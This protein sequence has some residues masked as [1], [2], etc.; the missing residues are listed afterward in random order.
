MNT[1]HA[2][3]F[4]SLLLSPIFLSQL[5][6]SKYEKILMT[7]IRDKNTSREKYRACV[8]KLANIL[9][10]KVYECLPTA[11]TVIDTPVDRYRGEKLSSDI[12]L[13]SVLRSGDALLTTFM[14]HFPE[15]RVSKILIQRNEKSLEPE[16]HYMKL[17]PTIASGNKVVITE[18][19]IGTGGTLNHVITKLKSRGVREENILI[20]SVCASQEGINRIKSKFPLIQVIVTE[21]DTELTDSGW[22]SPGLGDFGDR[23]FGTE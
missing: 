6:A 12:E 5:P 4:L 15:A 10:E 14:Q 3:V 22:I 8:D 13:L 23:F 16:F 2:F 19:M 21:V 11:E 20:A 7:Q 18:P 1:I 17:S 9:V